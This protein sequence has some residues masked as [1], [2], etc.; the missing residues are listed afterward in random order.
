MRDDESARRSLP[1]A[2]DLL[3][4]LIGAEITTVTGRPNEV[5]AVTGG[6]ALV[7]TD[8]APEGEAVPVR[9]VQQGLDVLATEGRVRVSPEVLGHRSS[10]V[11]AVLTT[12]PGAEFTG[13]PTFVVLEESAEEVARNRHYGELDAWSRVKVRAEQTRLR[14]LLAG[15]RDTA[16]CALCGESFPL[17]FLVAA[18]VKKR[19]SCS[20]EE[21]RDLDH[22][23]MLACGFGCDVLYE[24]G[25]IAVDDGGTVRTVPPED[26]PEGQLRDRLVHLRGRACSAFDTRSAPYFRWHRTTMFE[27]AGG[28][29]SPH[30]E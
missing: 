15:G 5:L 26:V 22:I 2:E 18:H 20:E 1:R 21:R 30:P 9:Q 6:S 24:S 23:A 28:G 4:D 7:R 29:G 17:R 14:A 8:R 13:R 27:P 19:A 10:F 11:G 16:A 25:W 3:R 12:L